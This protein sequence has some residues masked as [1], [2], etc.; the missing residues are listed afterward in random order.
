MWADV[1]EDWLARLP[2]ETLASS[3]DVRLLEPG[4]TEY[5]VECPPHGECG[6]QKRADPHNKIL[7]L[8]LDSICGTESLAANKSR[9]LV[10]LRNIS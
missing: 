1:A 7:A 4:C 2:V 9:A 8:L 6:R 10:L 3:I 5:R